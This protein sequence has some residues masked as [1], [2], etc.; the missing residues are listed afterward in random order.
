MTT[1]TD[2]TKNAPPAAEL[3]KTYDPQATEATVYRRWRDAGGFRATP[4]ERA[5]YCIT[6]PPPN[7]TGALHLGHA[8]NN[9]IM[10]ALGRWKRMQGYNTLILPGTDHA[11]IATQS[12]VERE[13]AKQGCTRYD[14]V[15]EG[16]VKRVWQWK[17]EYGDRI[18]NQL[19]RLGC[20]YDWDRLRF[21]MDERYVEAILTVFERLYEAG[22]IYL[23]R[24][25]V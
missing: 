21:T 18:V 11:G 15:R 23:G 24:R 3:P 4:D 8:L 25:I 17:H 7:V 13:I 2:E 10:D 19:Q 16:F 9:T 14:F 20:A 12:V 6:V 22:Y 1:A 5:P